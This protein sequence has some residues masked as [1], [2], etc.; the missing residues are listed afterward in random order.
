MT[1]AFSI[2]KTI[3]SGFCGA[4]GNDCTQHAWR[5]F[6]FLDPLID[7]G[8]V[9]DRA[10]RH[11]VPSPAHAF[12]H[13]PSRPSEIVGT[14]RSHALSR[15][16]CARRCFRAF[17]KIGEILRCYLAIAPAGFNFGKL[18]AKAFCFGAH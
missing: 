11:L 7:I 16:R 18:D 14:A 5:E 8:I 17:H 9:E 3:E 10:D 13:S 12:C 15:D 4:A 6:P 1:Q 2:E